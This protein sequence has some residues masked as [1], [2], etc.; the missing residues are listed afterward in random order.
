MNKIKQIPYGIADFETIMKGG[1]YYVDKTMYIP[2]VEEQPNYLMFTRP[3]GFGKSLLLTM[4]KTYYDKAKKKK[5]EEIFGSLWIGKHPTPLMG[6]Y[7]VMHLDFSQIVGTTE[8][9]R[10]QLDKHL[11][12]RLDDFVRKYADDFPNYFIK[13]F[14]ETTSG[15]GKLL[16]ISITAKSLRIPIYVFIDGFDEMTQVLL[17]ENITEDDMLSTEKV[18]VDFFN[19]IKGNIER[20]FIT[21]TE[22]ILFYNQGGGF[23]FGWNM[24]FFSC[25]DKLLGFTADD[26]REM[27]TYYKNI[28]ALPADSDTEGM[29]ETMR[30]WYGN[31]CFADKCLSDGNRVFNSGMVWHYLNEC[32][33][34]GHTPDTMPILSM[35]KEVN[36]IK[37]LTGL[38]TIKGNRKKELCEIT[39]KGEKKSIVETTLFANELLKPRMF[40][41]L[42]FY[43]GILTIKG[44]YEAQDILGIPNNNVQRVIERAVSR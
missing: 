28:G 5:F 38:D 3:S 9:L 19:K 10:E 44:K 7:L 37:R 36:L 12:S 26:V 16:M 17:D 33:K 42:L 27:F 39:E 18:F 31:Y 1:L 4:L 2:L 40:T 8:Q 11:C 34:C 25:F 14:F 30:A 20:I 29:I 15:D 6:K 23:N 22:P 24:S 35:E 32:I 13:E 21:G 43:H 41:S